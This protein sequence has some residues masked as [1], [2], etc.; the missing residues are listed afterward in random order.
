MRIRR[1]NPSIYTDFDRA[2]WAT[3]R[4]R[5]PLTLT[6]ADLLALR[7]LND[8]ISLD[9]VRDIYLP[10]S[11]LLGLRVA[12]AHSLVTV[13]SAFLGS[14]V[15][16]RPYIVAI[17]GSVAVGK[18]TTARVLQALLQRW[19]DHPHVE[20]VT[21]DG[22]LHPNRVL[23][24]RGLMK[25]KGFPQSYDAKRLLKF[26]AAIKAGEPEVT[27]P[28]Y[29]HLT[30][31]IVPD[32]VTVVR[33]PQICIIE[34]L[35]VL[36]NASARGSAARA[37]ISDYIDFSIYLDAAEE[38]V[39]SWYIERFLVLRDTVFHDASSYFHRYSALST[40]EARETAGR[41]WDEIN[42]PNLR[43]NI[44]PTRERAHVVLSKSAEH[45]VARVRLRSW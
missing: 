25:R 8:R 24:E 28:V 42:A 19:P 3:L 36:Q 45:S 37:L 11:R 16:R 7:G 23:E 17:A 40:A 22:F 10:L 21:T 33:Q 4:A 6:E 44:L 14:P 2:E 9:E 13:T 35:N 27:A 31:D 15:S 1:V 39:R 38:D 12:A 34:G 32:A 26:L 18:S 5:T 20:L 29:S 43:E 41:I 30:Y